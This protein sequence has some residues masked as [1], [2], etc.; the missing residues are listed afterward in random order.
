MADFD[1]AIKT[2]ETEVKAAQA[3]VAELTAKIE[4]VRAI[5]SLEQQ[6][7]FDVLNVIC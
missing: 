7:D 5:N 3:K 6:I 1:S 4:T 2:A